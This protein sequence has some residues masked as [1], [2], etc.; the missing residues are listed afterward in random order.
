MPHYFVSW[1]LEFS[2]YFSSIS[3]YCSFPITSEVIFFPSLSGTPSFRFFAIV[4]FIYFSIHAL[5]KPLALQSPFIVRKVYAL[6][7]SDILI[8]DVFK[9]F[10]G[11]VKTH[12]ETGSKN[13]VWG[14]FW[15]S[16]LLWAPSKQLK[17]LPIIFNSIHAK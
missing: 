8:Q 14:N 10:W 11:T 2:L 1:T 16:F 15:I 5:S 9:R 17:C 7:H 13:R 3:P 4:C 6:W 12:L